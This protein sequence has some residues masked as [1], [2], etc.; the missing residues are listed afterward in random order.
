MSRNSSCA[1]CA[2]L[3]TSLVRWVFTTMPSVQVV[4]QAVNGLR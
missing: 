1:A 3:A 2:A 4:V